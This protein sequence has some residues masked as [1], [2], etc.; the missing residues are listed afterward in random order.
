[1]TTG[2]VL[3]IGGSSGLGLALA[4]LLLSGGAEV[5]IASRSAERLAAAAAHLRAAPDRLRTQVLDIRDEDGVRRGLEASVPVHHIAVTA[6]DATRATGPLGG[7]QLTDARAVMDAKFFGPW[8]VGRYAAGHLPPTGSSVTAA[9][10]AAVEGLV[11][12]LALELAPV[13]VNAVSPGWMDTPLWDTIAGDRRAERLAEMA[14]RLP[15][16]RVARPTDVAE[17]FVALMDNAHITGTVLHVDG[18]QRLV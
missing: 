4:G 3:V 8:L 1:M 18:G 11:G 16:G 5:T 15:V 10:N 6:A 9:A 17:A 12:A 2:H 14:A 7:F 13:R